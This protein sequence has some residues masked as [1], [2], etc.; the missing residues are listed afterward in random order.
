MYKKKI[1][2]ATLWNRCLYFSIQV[3]KQ[4]LFVFLHVE[5]SRI[6]R[7]NIFFKHLIYF[8]SD[9]FCKNQNS[10][11]NIWIFEYLELEVILSIIVIE[12]IKSKVS[13][14]KGILRDDCAIRQIPKLLALDAFLSRVNQMPCVPLRP[15]VWAKLEGNVIFAFTTSMLRACAHVCTFIY[16]RYANNNARHLQWYN[17]MKAYK[18]KCDL[19]LIDFKR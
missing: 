11:W 10:K 9:S 17:I 12:S 16:Y 18:K 1:S 13:W 5:V 14:F 7:E 3:K 2:R 19:R 15:V 6:I 8:L 4:S